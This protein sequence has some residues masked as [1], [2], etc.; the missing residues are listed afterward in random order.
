MNYSL[1]CWMLDV[2][3]QWP[4]GGGTKSTNVALAKSILMHG[5]GDDN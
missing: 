1:L 3:T 5:S 4:G 2:R